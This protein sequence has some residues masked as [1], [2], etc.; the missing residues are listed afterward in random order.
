MTMKVIRDHCNVFDIMITV[1]CDHSDTLDIMTTFVIG[2]DCDYF[3]DRQNT[4]T[5]K[6]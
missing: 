1:T 5:A 4:D 3:N 2:D 6:G